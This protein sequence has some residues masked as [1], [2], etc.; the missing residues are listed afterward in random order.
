MINKT[1]RKFQLRT[2]LV[3]PFVLQ[4]V[5]AVG[6]VG[7]LSFQSGQRSINNL[8]TQLLDTVNNRVNQHLET[9]LTIPHQVNQINNDNIQLGLLDIKNFPVTRQYFWNLIQRFPTT[10]FIAFG[11][12]QQEFIGVERL[13]SRK[14]SAEIK[15][16]STGV[17]KLVYLFD[18]QGNLINKQ[19]GISKKY[20]PT[21][22]PWYRAAK[23]ANKPTWSKIYQFSS[24]QAVRLGITAVLPYRDRAGKFVGVL[25]TDLVV[26]QISEFLNQIKISPSGRIFI[27]D[28]KGLLVAS[29]TQSPIY[30]VKNGKAE[31]LAASASSD[32]FIRATRESLSKQF[33]DLNQITKLQQLNFETNGQRQFALV[34]PWQDEFGLN[35]VIVTTVPESDFMAD[36]NANNRNTILL[37][38]ATL[39]LTILIGILTAQSITLP[40]IKITKASKEIATGNLDERVD[41]Q[42]FIEIQEIDTLEHSFNSMAG[43]LKSSFASLETK[44][45]ELRIAEESYRS[46]FENALDGIFQSSPEGQFIKVNSA[47]AKIYGY[48]SPREMIETI[49]GISDQIYV[50][51]EKR[52]EFKEL[53]ETQGMAKDFEYRSYCKDRSIIWTQIDARAVKD[54][55]DKI[56][57][58]EGLVQNISDR[59][60]REDELR[61]QLEELKIEIDHTKREKEVAMLTESSFFQEVKQEMAEVNLDEFWS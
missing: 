29:S 13:E 45:E 34:E 33:G 3:V 22:R 1:P 25:S 11:N 24:N 54:S 30:T 32:P 14:F 37:C 57:Y 27:M 61:R 4:T 38:L 20:L 43:Q 7:Y 46:I 40:I 49:T 56:L 31:R 6:L 28:R 10:G 2:A 47:M 50:D 42:D 52:A 36:I 12:E 58:Y 9:Y 60:R 17:N 59:K 8:V 15:D 55:T 23:E 26:S 16:K 19:I 18:Q 5:A 53:L 48:D 35:W 41:T 44:N 39:V 51:P 21:S